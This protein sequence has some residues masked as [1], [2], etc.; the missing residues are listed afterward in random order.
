[1][2]FVNLNDIEDVVLSKFEIEKYLLNI[3]K[4]D[5]KQKLQDF[6]SDI[7]SNMWVLVVNNKDIINFNV[8]KIPDNDFVFVITSEENEIKLLEII[9][10]KYDLNNLTEF[11]PEYNKNPKYYF[12][13][14]QTYYK[15]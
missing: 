8:V 7:S 10:Q 14:K 15:I 1:M 2:K 9:L 12:I 11:I 3:K 13:H 6:I 4:I 5:Q